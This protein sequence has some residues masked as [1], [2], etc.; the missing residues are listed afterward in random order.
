M[1]E[2]AEIACGKISRSQ[3]RVC[4]WRPFGLVDQAAWWSTWPATISRKDAKLIIWNTI[5]DYSSLIVH[6]SDRLM[7]SWLCCWMLPKWACAASAWPR[8]SMTGV[9]NKTINMCVISLTRKRKNRTN[10]MQGPVA[11]GRWHRARRK[12]KEAKEEKMSGTKCAEEREKERSAV[13]D[14]SCRS[15]RSMMADRAKRHS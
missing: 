3:K 7:V 15:G 10:N 14:E 4:Q 8:S 1:I 11:K 9:E 5:I 12:R 13:Q 2:A 6:A